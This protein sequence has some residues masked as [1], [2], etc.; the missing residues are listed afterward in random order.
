MDRLKLRVFPLYF[1]LVILLEGL[2]LLVLDEGE[3]DEVED[4]LGQFDNPAGGVALMSEHKEP[5]EVVDG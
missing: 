2:D 4:E 3:G 1:I 5:D